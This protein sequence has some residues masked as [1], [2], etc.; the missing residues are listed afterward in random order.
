MAFLY[1][2]YL[3]IKPM[4]NTRGQ[5]IDYVI[6]S[7]ED[8]KK[9]EGILKDHIKSK[10]DIDI[11]KND[12]IYKAYDFSFNKIHKIEYKGLYYKLDKTEN[13]A[14]QNKNNNVKISDVIIS[15][16]KI[17]YYKIR[18]MKNPLLK[19]YLI[20]GFYTIINNVVSNINYRY[21]DISNLDHII[22]NNKTMVFERAKHYKISIKD[23]LKLPT[24]SPFNL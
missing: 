23:L 2:L 1:I 12:D 4:L 10:Y 18:Q 13:I 21:I 9:F 17:A 20:Y 7:V 24:E 5:S 11:I 22:L 8:N 19:F 6:K 16:S 14:V 15:K 3:D